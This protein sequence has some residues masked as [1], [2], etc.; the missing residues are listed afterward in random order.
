MITT[1]LF[2]QIEFVISHGI[3]LLHITSSLRKE[4]HTV[5]ALQEGKKSQRNSLCIQVLERFWSCSHQYVPSSAT[6]YGRV[7]TQ[8]LLAFMSNHFRHPKTGVKS[9]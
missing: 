6:R 7:F 3:P 8:K 5:R 1:S 9:I 4:E 2:Q